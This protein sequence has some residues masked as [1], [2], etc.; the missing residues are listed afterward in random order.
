MGSTHRQGRFPQ[1]RDLRHRDGCEILLGDG[2]GF[3]YPGPVGSLIAARWRDY[4][5]EGYDEVAE[6]YLTGVLD[7]I[8]HQFSGRDAEVIAAEDGW[9]AFILS[10]GES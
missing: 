10:D 1:A 8:R 7:G 4:L 6:G 9:N 2:R 3:V 5:D